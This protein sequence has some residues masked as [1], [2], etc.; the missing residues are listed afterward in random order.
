MEPRLL[1]V[2]NGSSVTRMLGPAGIPGTT[3]IWADPLHNGPVPGGIDD[4]ALMEVRAR[5]HAPSPNAGKLL[6]EFILSRECG[7]IMVKQSQDPVNKNVKPGT[8][9]KPWQTAQYVWYRVR[10]RPA[11][12]AAAGEAAKSSPARVARMARM[13]P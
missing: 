10:P 13:P 6:M 1:H 8:G 5:Y 12:A 7:E 9:G 3:S 4:A 2:A 11:S